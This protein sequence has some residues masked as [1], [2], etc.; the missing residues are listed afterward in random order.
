MGGTFQACIVD[1]QEN[2]DLFE[3]CLRIHLDAGCQ[4]FVLDR[5]GNK[6]EDE[7]VVSVFQKVKDICIISENTSH[8]SCQ[9]CQ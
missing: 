4:K 6:H 2:P 5:D 9:G 3:P 1:N 7:Q 8:S